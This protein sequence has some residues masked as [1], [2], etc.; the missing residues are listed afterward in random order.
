MAIISMPGSTEFIFL[1]IFLVYWIVIID[2]VIAI[3]KSPEI[4][5]VTGI[6]WNLVILAFPII[7]LLFFNFFGPQ[8][9]RNSD[10]RIN[11]GA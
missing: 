5:L 8:I 4:D 11:K 9:K 3:F 2:T 7:G 1:A 6:L 10:K